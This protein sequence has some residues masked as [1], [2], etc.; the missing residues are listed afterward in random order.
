MLDAQERIL[1]AHAP[2]SRGAG[3]YFLLAD[4]GF[5]TRSGASLW[6]STDHISHNVFIKPFQKVKCLT[7]STTYCSEFVI[8]NNEV[9]I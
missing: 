7:R 4:T 8:G 1:N 3:W 9:T 2:Q 6:P 5:D